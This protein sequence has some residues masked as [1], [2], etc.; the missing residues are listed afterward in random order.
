MEG[1]AAAGGR[2][3]RI[4]IF[5]IF[6]ALLAASVGWYLLS[7]SW[8]LHEMKVAAKAGDTDRLASYIDFPALRASFK[9]EIH[10]KAATELVG[11]KQSGFG[12]LGAMFALT[13]ADRMIDGL[14]TPAAMRNVF[15]KNKDEGSGPTAKFDA[16]DDKL[17]VKREG[18]DTFR[19]QDPAKNDGGGLVFTRH[20]LSWRLSGVR[21]PAG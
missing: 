11:G 15:L 1:A 7:P 8:T 13:M 17:V 19:L 10:A 18:F 4:W 9:E 6:A 5:A 3:R 21:L 20:G 12:A 16:S 14:V 2:S